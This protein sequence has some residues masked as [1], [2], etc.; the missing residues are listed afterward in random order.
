MMDKIKIDSKQRTILV[1]DS[2]KALMRNFQDYLEHH[3][4][5]GKYGLNFV[6][7]DSA[8]M[9]LKKLAEMKIDL[10]VLE[11]ILPVVNGYYLLKALNK[12]KNKIPVIIYT[13]LKGPQDLAKM[14]ALNVD[15]IFIKQLMKMEDLIQIIISHEDNKVELDKV[16]IELQSQ[17]KSISDNEI[18]PSLKIV[19]CP[20]CNMI[21]TRD[22]HFCN[23][24][25][26]KIVHVTSKKLQAAKAP[27]EK[28]ITDFEKAA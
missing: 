8:K 7:A 26:Q 24:C 22:S 23:N 10:I 21:L 20:R 2:D 16:L 11:I 9:A 17:I 4:V 18:E 25:G 19:Q 12:E 14:A 1:V 6:F 27:G 28:T 5:K 15:N 13:R 3:E